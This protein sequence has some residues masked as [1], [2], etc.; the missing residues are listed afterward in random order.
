M[1]Q[2]CDEATDLV[3]GQ[4]KLL[5]AAVTWLGFDFF[6]AGSSALTS[7]LFLPAALALALG[8][9]AFSF[10]FSFFTLGDMALWLMLQI[11][12][13]W[14]LKDCHDV[15]VLVMSLLSRSNIEKMQSCTNPT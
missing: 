10:H 5:L 1:L 2:T 4:C 3:S 8:V 15:L 9:A 12:N 13:C 14:D 7:S 6:V 11:K